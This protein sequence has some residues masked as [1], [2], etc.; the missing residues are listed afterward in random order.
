MKNI[1]RILVIAAAT[2]MASSAF[3]QETV[4][5]GLSASA[6]TNFA[7]FLGL[8]IAAVGGAIGQSRVAA[9]A[10]E[11]IARNPQADKA[12]FT[13]FILALAFIEA[14]VIFVLVIALIKT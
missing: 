13:P 9:A 3:A 10:L 7:A 6:L 11:G 1:V 5:A 14:I 8:A 12:I 4:S 2:L